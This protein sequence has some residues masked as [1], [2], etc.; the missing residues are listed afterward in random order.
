MKQSEFNNDASETITK[1][2]D[3]F[4]INSLVFLKDFGYQTI[5]SCR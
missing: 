5:I 1:K 2:I 4:F 3:Y